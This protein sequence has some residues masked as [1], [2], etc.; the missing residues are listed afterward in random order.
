M[1]TWWQ[2]KNGTALVRELTA[3]RD[4]TDAELYSLSSRERKLEKVRELLAEHV[5]VFVIFNVEMEGKQG[6]G[7]IT[8]KGEEHLDAMMK[9][10]SDPLMVC[11]IPAYNALDARCLLEHLSIDPTSLSNP[12]IFVKEP[13]H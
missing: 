13:R 9:G 5:V 3:L 1:S 12:L 10:D 6:I 8:I 4:I 11:G 7:S 2:G